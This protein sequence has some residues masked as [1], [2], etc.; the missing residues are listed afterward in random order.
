MARIPPI[1]A[2]DQDELARARTHFEDYL[3]AQDLKLTEQRFEI[4]DRVSTIGRHFTADD[5][6]DEFRRRK[7]GPS[8]STI[9][10]TLTLLTECNILEEHKFA[11][12]PSSVYE[13]AWG[14]DHHDHLICTTC[15]AII[16]FFDEKLENVQDSA[17]ETLGFE[18][19]SH[20]LKIYGTC[21]ACVSK[22]APATP[23]AV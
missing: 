23:G 20:S 12:N 10:R 16:E 11:N 15:G 21:A 19:L 6:V 5:L 18:P 14:R 2:P 9:Y 8:K 4:L 7:A 3:R 17:A 22:R 13:L 1:T